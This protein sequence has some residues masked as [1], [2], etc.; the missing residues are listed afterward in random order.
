MR[1]PFL[2]LLLALSACGA[3][4]PSPKTTTENFVKALEERRYS[5]AY[6]ELSESAR[7][8]LSARDF[9]ALLRAHPEAEKDI[10]EALRADL[11]QSEVSVI[12]RTKSGRELRLFLEDGEYRLDES[13]LDL[14]PQR[15]PVEA[16][17][18]FVAALERGRYDVLLSFVP[19]DQSEGV[20]EALLR[21]SFSGPQKSEID[22]LRGSL[23]PSLAEA[24]VEILGERAVVSYG[25][26]SRVELLLEDGLWKIEDFK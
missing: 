17:R 8:R 24:K 11:G 19:R 21:E 1:A 26:E 22:H 25:T 15:T 3:P 5:D 13:A 16:L 2:C 4:K 18:S 20:T 7:A 10:I 9:E 6:A 23:A 12:L 14:Y